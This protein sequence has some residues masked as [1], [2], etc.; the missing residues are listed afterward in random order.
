M[1]T[2]FNLFSADRQTTEESFRIHSSKTPEFI[3]V[4]K[5]GCYRN[6]KI[7][8]TIV[9]FSFSGLALKCLYWVQFGFMTHHGKQSGLHIRDETKLSY[10]QP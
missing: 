8:V 1:L 10:L 4:V 6:K 2:V 3:V 7:I 9:L 5:R